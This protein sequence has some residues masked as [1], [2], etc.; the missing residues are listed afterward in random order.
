MSGN[1]GFIVAPNGKLSIEGASSSEDKHVA[2]LASLVSELR[3]I[4][5]EL[6]DKQLASVL[7][8]TQPN[9]ALHLNHL[10]EKEGWN[11]SDATESVAAAEVARTGINVFENNVV[12][13]SAEVAAASW[14]GIGKHST[15][16]PKLFLGGMIK[17]VLKQVHPDSEI[18]ATGQKLM[19]DL[20]AFAVDTMLA[21][22]DGVSASASSDQFATVHTNAFLEDNSAKKVL[23]SRLMPRDAVLVQHVDGDDDCSW[24]LRSEVVRVG[25]AVALASFEAKT[26]AEQEAVLKEQQDLADDDLVEDDSWALG[27]V[28]SSRNIQT[29]VRRVFPGELAK[30]AVSEGTKAVTKFSWGTRSEER[31]SISFKDGKMQYHGKLTAESDVNDVNSALSRAAGLQAPVLEIAHVLHTRLGNPPSLTAAVYLAATMEYLAAEILELSGNAAR[32]NKSSWIQPRH[33]FLAMRGDEELHKMFQNVSMLDSGVL[34]NIHSVFLPRWNSSSSPSERADKVVETMQAYLKDAVLKERFNDEGCDH[35]VSGTRPHGFDID[36]SQICDEICESGLE[37]GILSSGAA[38]VH[39]CIEDEEE[40]FTSLSKVDQAA[41]LKPSRDK[42]KVSTEE[43]TPSVHRKSSGKAGVRRHRK[44]LRDNIQGIE[45]EMILA[46]AA[47]AGCMM[48]SGLVYE[49]TRGITK[50]YLEN[51]IRDAVT[52]TEHKRRKVVLAID[53][54]AAAAAPGG[55]VSL[56]VVCGTGRIASMYATSAA[57]SSSS[58]SG[59]GGTPSAFA[60]LAAEYSAELARGQDDDDEDDDVLLDMCNEDGFNE[61]VTS[62]WDA[63]L[64]EEDPYGN[65]REEGVDDVYDVYTYKGRARHP[66][67]VPFLTKEE[68]F[69]DPAQCHKD[70]LGYIRQ[71]QRSSGPCIPFLPLSRLIREIAQDFKTDLDFE[72][73]A[74][75]VIQSMLET[76]LVELF[77]DANRSCIHGGGS[78]HRTFPFRGYDAEDPE[79]REGRS[80][81]IQPKDLQLA[82]RIRK[83]RL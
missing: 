63:D 55:H 27:G 67:G 10:I 38:W 40:P 57:G 69:A 2:A 76:Y 22:V 13:Y 46:L 81:A 9:A 52:I 51:L 24:E 44:I 48:L 82:R 62:A 72:P 3:D 80:F 56:K 61:A 71:M 79:H 16:V 36:D 45:R 19:S 41:V 64:D 20:I 60:K 12:A 43:I 59:G 65:I 33:V 39:A 30:H 83:E 49:E 26:A 18:S 77:E 37:G 5:P 31:D 11:Y 54:L 21:A 75:R 53:V 66:S 78:S 15:A 35:F 14:E 70:A 29:A 34:P 32:D 4:Q 47:R 7:Y 23:A 74:L 58:S 50:V 17:K 6:V 25:L 73:E 42:A 28:T 1:M 8:Q 68:I